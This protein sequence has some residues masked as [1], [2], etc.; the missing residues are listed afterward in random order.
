[1]VMLA[2]LMMGNSYRKSQKFIYFAL[3]LGAE[4]MPRKQSPRGGIRALAMDA[5]TGT[6]MNLR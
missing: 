2:E 1:M 4:T 3:T 6:T 5:P